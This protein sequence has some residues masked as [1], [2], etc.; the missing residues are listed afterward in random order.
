MW[1]WVAV[2]VLALAVTGI[3]A[4][5]VLAYKGEIPTMWRMLDCHT[6]HV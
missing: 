3:I 6:C 4:C 2:G 1:Y 5:Y